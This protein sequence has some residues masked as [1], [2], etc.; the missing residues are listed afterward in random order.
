MGMSPGKVKRLMLRCCGCSDVSDGDGPSLTDDSSSNAF[1]NVSVV[2]HKSRPLDMLG[3]LGNDRLFL[4]R[5]EAPNRT[6]RDSAY[7]PP[8]SEEAGNG[9][10]LS[11]L[12]GD[13]MNGHRVS[14]VREMRKI[15]E[16]RHYDSPQSIL[17]WRNSIWA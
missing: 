4:E 15:R 9:H 10:R 6:Q 5:L 7:E 2:A 1:D 12:E 8:G 11:M 13:D 17:N 14:V 16:I 3:F